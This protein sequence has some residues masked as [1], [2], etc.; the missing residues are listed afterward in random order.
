MKN[1]TTINV[2]TKCIQIDMKIIMNQC[3]MN[4]LINKHLNHIFALCLKISKSICNVNL[5]NF[6]LSL[7][8]IIYKFHNYFF[9]FCVIKS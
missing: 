3:D 1:A 9:F 2:T 7:K 6:L 5:V 4:D 8:L